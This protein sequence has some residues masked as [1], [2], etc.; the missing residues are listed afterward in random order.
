MGL[1]AGLRQGFG[2]VKQAALCRQLL[3]ACAEH[4]LACQYG[5]FE[6]AN[7]V[8]VGF[9]TNSHSLLMHGLHDCSMGILLGHKQCLEGLNVVRQNAG[10]NELSKSHFQRRNWLL[11]ERK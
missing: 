7:D 11:K 5:L 2:F 1:S 3:G 10:Q 8:I 4:A 9:L 6:H